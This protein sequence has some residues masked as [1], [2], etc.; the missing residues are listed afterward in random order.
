MARP[1]LILIE[2]GALH[3]S[4]HSLHKFIHIVSNNVL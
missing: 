1:I 2:D 3:F 4:S